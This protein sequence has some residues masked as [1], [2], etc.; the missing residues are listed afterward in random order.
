MT[1]PLIVDKNPLIEKKNPPIVDIKPPIV[2]IKPLIDI[3]SKNLQAMSLKVLHV[4]F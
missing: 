4:K 2:D 1:K 3:K